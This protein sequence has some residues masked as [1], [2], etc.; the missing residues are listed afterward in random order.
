MVQ[1]R[2]YAGIIDHFYNTSIAVEFIHR[3]QGNGLC[4]RRQ[5]PCR[6]VT[7]MGTGF[8]NSTNMT[9]H[10]T[11]FKVQN[12]ILGIV[13]SFFLP[14]FQH[15]RSR[16]VYKNLRYKH[17]LTELLGIAGRLKRNLSISVTFI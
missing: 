14:F 12:Y 9:C 10:I 17:Y 15:G 1:C 16:I 6:K 5:R 4:D 2:F 13:I 11:K 7:V 3:L 8:V